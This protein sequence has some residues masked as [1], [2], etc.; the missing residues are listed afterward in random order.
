MIRPK[1]LQRF[2]ALPIPK[3]IKTPH[4]KFSIISLFDGSGSF[5][6]VISQALEAWPHA[7]LAAENEP[8]TRSVV[9]KVKGWPLDGTLWAYD[10][11]G[12]H[13][14]YAK[15]VWALIQNHCLILKQFLSLLPE[16]SVIFLA[17]GFPCPDL[18]VI[19]RG[20]GLL[21]LAGDR[22]VLIHCGWAVLYYLSLTPWWHKVIV[23]FEN[24]GSMKDH[25]KTYIHELLGIPIKCAHYINCSTWGSVSR[26]R[27]FF[28][29]SD[30]V[31][32]PTTAHLLLLMT[33]G[34]LRCTLQNCN[35]AL[36]HHG[37]DHVPLLIWA[38]LFKLLW[39]IIPKIC[40]MIS[41]FSLAYQASSKPVSL[42]HLSFILSFLF[43]TFSHLSC[44]TNGIPWNHGLR[45][46]QWN[47]LQ[48]FSK[49]F[50][51]YRIFTL[52]PIFTFLFVFPHFPRKLKILNCLN[53]FSPLLKKLPRLFLPC[54]T[55]LA[56]SLSQAL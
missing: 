27:Y 23:L 39:L 38:M 9:A 53:C 36:C 12:A 54:I 56:T 19:G 24:A 26:A 4:S 22:S 40:S 11:R 5:V 28:A 35:P 41:I 51:V 14:F 47:S 15:D 2:A 3:T 7:I 44:G 21:G 1:L 16:D 55:L 13:S 31:V 17:A 42:M 49:L 34:Y 20:N 18:T 45:I 43:L 30:I 8:G 50:H 25:M 37:F 48:L 10:K 29:S 33:A 32:L 6:D 52:T 46:S